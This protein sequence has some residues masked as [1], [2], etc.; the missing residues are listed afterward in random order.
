M[1]SISIDEQRRSRER[2]YMKYNLVDVEIRPVKVYSNQIDSLMMIII[3]GQIHCIARSLDCRLICRFSF[4]SSTTNEGERER[5]TI[6]IKPNRCNH[7][8]IIA[9]SRAP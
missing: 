1:N 8:L 3:G 7:F 6:H 2:T 5:S 4:K 9:L